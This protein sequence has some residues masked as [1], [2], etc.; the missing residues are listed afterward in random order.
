[1]NRTMGD[2]KVT[3]RTKDGMFNATNL[4]KQWNDV[5][6]SNKEIASYFKM[7]STIE[8][9]E[10]MEDDTEFLNMA[11]SPYVKSRASRGK[12][13]GTW[14]HPYLFIDF[15]MWINPK[16]KLQVIKFVYDEMIKYRNQSG[17]AYTELA[18]SVQILVGKDF[19]RS[20]MVRISKGINHIVFDNHK[21]AIRNEFGDEK[22]Q[23]ELY[24]LETKLSYLINEGFITSYESLMHYLVKKY[25]TKKIPF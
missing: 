23:R 13:T 16:F 4:L 25:K 20:A 18:R 22:T 14:M 12:N 6:N 21:K 19:I 1:M 15:A 5:N 17:S 9:I 7:K 8:F 10:T 3:Q 11:I 24:E 2:L